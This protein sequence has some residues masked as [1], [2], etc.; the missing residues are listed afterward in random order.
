MNRRPIA[1]LPEALGSAA[2]WRRIRAAGERL[3]ALDYDGTL[4]PFTVE[5]MAGRPLPGAL[6]EIERIRDQGGARLALLSGR[7]LDEL[8]REA[9]KRLRG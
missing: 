3:L 8:L 9:L 2:L 6:A 4:A 1:A 7:P 5:R